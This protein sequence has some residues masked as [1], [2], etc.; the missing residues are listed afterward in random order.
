MKTTLLSL[1]FATAL[2]A[3]TLPTFKENLEPKNLLRMMQTTHS[4]SQSSS[5]C[6]RQ[7]TMGSV[8]II[9]LCPN[10]PELRRVTG[11]TIFPDKRGLQIFVR[12]TDPTTQAFKV[13][14]RFRL[15][16]GEEQTVSEYTS[17]HPQYDSA[18]GWV[19]GDIEII[20]V[21][22]IELRETVKHEL[23]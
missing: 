8:R 5:M 11:Q 21:T 1:L 23:Q 6:G 15:D 13:Q 20:G 18:V 14:V 12:T 7:E 16:G 17:V 22:V 3:Q 9:I 2:G 19:L 4:E 10:W